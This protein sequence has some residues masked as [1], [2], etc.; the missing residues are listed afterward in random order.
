MSDGPKKK[1][2]F[3]ALSPERLRELAV[4]GG[5]A[6]HAQGVG[7]KWT[8]ETAREAGRKGGGAARKR[9]ASVS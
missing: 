2:G 4:M 1:R 7:H 3:A 8:S 5:R 6:A 9:R